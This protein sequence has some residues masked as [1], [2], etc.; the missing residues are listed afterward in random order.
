MSETIWR[1]QI[2]Q[3]ARMAGGEL[4][5]VDID[6][7]AFDT[8]LAAESELAALRKC[9]GRTYRLAGPDG[10]VSC[11]VPAHALSGRDLRKA[12]SLDGDRP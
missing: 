2:L 3:D 11:T 8:R 12:L 1:V 4:G 5:Y 9:T 7:M 10:F 6:G